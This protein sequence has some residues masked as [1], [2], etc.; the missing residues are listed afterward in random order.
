MSNQT[1]T[2]RWVYGGKTRNKQKN[3]DDGKSELKVTVGM[4]RRE[5]LRRP[6]QRAW[7]GKMVIRLVS[8]R[9]RERRQS[10][11]Q[12]GGEGTHR[13][14]RVSMPADAGW[15]V[16]GS[17]GKVAQPCPTLC[18]P[19]TIQSMGFSRPEQWSGEPVP[20]PGDLPNP[21]TE[22][23]SPALQADSLPAEPPGKP[24]NNGVGSLSLLQGIFP[25]QELNWAFLN[26]RR[27]LYQL[28]YQGSPKDM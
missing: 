16:K 25:T 27:I 10:T 26:C 22:P 19:W 7:G 23:R 3:P 17:E 21:G 15:N 6:V 20:S 18:D 14:R 11:L 5:R 2:H 28:S 12:P 9:K 4:E 24:K 1:T 8:P 13:R